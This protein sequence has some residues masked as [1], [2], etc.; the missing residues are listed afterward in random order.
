[1]AYSVV[2]CANDVI[3]LIRGRRIGDG[4]TTEGERNRDQYISG[5]DKLLPNTP[6]AIEIKFN[7]STLRFSIVI[8]FHILVTLRSFIFGTT[9]YTHTLTHFHYRT[10]NN[11]N[12]TVM[13]VINFMHAFRIMGVRC[14][15]RVFLIHF[16]SPLVYSS[17]IYF[18]Y[19]TY[20]TRVCLKRSN[21]IHDIL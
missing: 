4:K 1:M 12:S 15:S 11:D 10:L 5:V 18:S 3:A 21:W 6:N 13:A 20:M 17:I 2:V 16:V 7:F 9:V 14:G 8:I 19:M